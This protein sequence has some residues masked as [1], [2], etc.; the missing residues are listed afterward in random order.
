MFFFEY[1][2]IVQFGRDKVTHRGMEFRFTMDGLW[3]R[4]NGYGRINRSVDWGDWRLEI[5]DW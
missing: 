3:N 5:G 4:W 1:G 2:T